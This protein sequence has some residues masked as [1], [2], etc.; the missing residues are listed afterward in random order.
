MNPALIYSSQIKQQTTLTFSFKRAFL[1]IILAWL[2]FE[3]TTQSLTVNALADAFWAV[4]CYVAMTLAVYHSLS[5]VFSRYQWAT[6]LI[7]KSRNHQVFFAALMGALPGCGGAIIVTTQFIS[8]RLGFGAVVAVLV[9]TMGDAAFLLLASEPSTGIAMIGLG[10]VVG[11]ISGVAVNALHK[12]DFLRP[13]VKQ[14]EF[15]APS[16]AASLEST[17]NNRV[18]K[19]ALSLQGAFWAIMIIP[20]SFIALLGSFQVETNALFGLPEGSM[21][22]LGALL[23]LA[24][25]SLWSFTK[26]IEDYR[27]VVS[28]DEKTLGSHPMQKTAQDTNFVTAWVVVAFLLFEF[29]AEFTHTDFHQLFASWGVWLPFA[30]ILMGLL[31]GCGPQLLV[32]S[33]YLSGALPL[34][35]QIGN[36]IS[37]DG[38]A[39][40]PAIAMAPKAAL[41]ATFYSAVPSFITAYSYWWLFE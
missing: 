7:H 25:I 14:R 38:D 35:A 15:T 17:P 12:D 3:P 11:T 21:E 40:F 1:P 29:G 37:N 4:S 30:G 36:A 8:G 39:L 6:E 19:K 31:P 27:T 9:S 18:V 13:K 32:T 22:W 28:E 24:S 33:L 16:C 34:S 5:N 20:G 26:E 10:I 41:V 2:L 23:L